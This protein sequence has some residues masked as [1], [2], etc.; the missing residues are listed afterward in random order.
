MGSAVDRA[1]GTLGGGAGKWLGLWVLLLPWLLGCF[2]NLPILLRSGP[3]L[4]TGPSETE[5][6]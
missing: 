1:K 5:C 6:L 2:V 3:L 4:R